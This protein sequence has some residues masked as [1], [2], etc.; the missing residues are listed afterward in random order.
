[1]K[2]ESARGKDGGKRP[3]AGVTSQIHVNDS[4]LVGKAHTKNLY[5]KKFSA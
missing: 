4:I 1:M 2:G 5:F 3:K